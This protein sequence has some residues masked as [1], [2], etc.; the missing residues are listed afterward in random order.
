MHSKYPGFRNLGHTCYLNAVLQCLFNNNGFM[1]NFALL[2]FRTQTWLTTNELRLFKAFCLL[3]QAYRR[4]DMG[5]IDHL[6]SFMTELS[7]VLTHYRIGIQQDAHEFLIQLLQFI[8]QSF[9]R[10]NNIP[11]QVDHDP[12][13]P[14]NVRDTYIAE[15]ETT[16]TCS[17]CDINVIQT[18][19]TFGLTIQI[20]SDEDSII[21]SIQDYFKES[22]VENYYCSNCDARNNVKQRIFPKFIPDTVILT[23]ARYSQVEVRFEPYFII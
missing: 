19:Q 12:L 8:E 11:Q 20:N 3:Y 13:D 10:V 21:R 9:L 15:I 2:N 5:L 6:N 4:H 23:I 17:N 7:R 22:Q 18:D 1:D 16:L 14:N